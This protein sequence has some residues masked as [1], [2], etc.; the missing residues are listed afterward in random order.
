MRKDIRAK[1]RLIVALDVDTDDQALKIVEQLGDSV[2]FYKVGWQL[3]FSSGFDIVHKLADQ[4]KKVFLDLK[5]HD[6]GTTIRQ[7]IHNA[8]TQSVK[9]IE[10]MTLNGAGS[11]VKAA[12]D[13][14]KNE[15]LKFLMLTVLSSMDNEDIK[16][17]YGEEATLE[18][19]ILHRAKKALEANCDGLIASGES[20]RDLRKHFGDDFFI[21]TP[22]VRPGGCTTDDHKRSLTPYDAILYGADYLVVGR[23]ITQ[24]DEPKSVAESILGEIQNGLEDKKKGL[25]E[26]FVA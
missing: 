16:E 22:G 5:M 26:N 11:I 2:G 18:K 21:V 20:V 4:H 25:A 7:A 15:H 1:E 13:G 24:S 3:F 17:V 19:V 12:K 6:I 8:P 9:C 23:P 14:S 10:L